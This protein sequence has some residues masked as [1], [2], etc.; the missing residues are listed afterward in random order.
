M[1][2][3]TKAVRVGQPVYGGRQGV[4]SSESFDSFAY[5]STLKGHLRRQGKNSW[6]L[7]VDLGRDPETGKRRQQWVTVRGTERQ[8]RR[9]LNELLADVQ[10]GTYVEPVKL[11]LGEFLARWLVDYARGAV[12]P[13]TLDLYAM[14]IRVHIAPTIGRVR[15]DRL[16]PVHLQRLYADKLS[17]GRADGSGGLSPQTVRHMHTVLHRALRHAVQ[18]GLLA[19]NIADAVSPPHPERKT[20]AALSAEELSRFLEACTEERLGAFFVLAATT[21]LRRGEVAALQWR[22]VD[23]V[24]RI[25]TVRRALHY[26][27]S[28]EQVFA[29]PKT[30]TSRRQVTLPEVAVDALLRHRAAQDE[31]RTWPDYEDQRL[32][33]CQPNGRPIDVHNLS[34]RSFKRIL[35]R[36]GL[37]DIRLHD[38]RH[39][40]A[41]LLL[42]AGVHPKKVQERLGHSSIRLT[43]DTYSHLMPAAQEETAAAVDAALRKGERRAK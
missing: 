17:A 34:R 37:P 43:L 26:L 19:R 3:T 38:L 9:K 27:S 30:L 16:Q 2:K 25:L 32:V 24:R 13:K 21:G 4:R 22:D 8:A 23:L 15:L 36:A 29:E 1:D 11:T 18:W 20:V 42:E 31:E 12:R 5:I 10:K 28:G 6:A 41:S 35:K 33:F 7:V 40:H 39:S 14:L